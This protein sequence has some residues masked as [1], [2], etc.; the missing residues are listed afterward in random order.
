LFCFHDFGCDFNSG[1]DFNFYSGF[2]SG[3]DFNSGYDFNFGS[4][5]N[6][7]SNSIGDKYR[8]LLHS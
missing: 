4:G 1:Y 2:I 7:D 8:T 5:F 6:F 3:S